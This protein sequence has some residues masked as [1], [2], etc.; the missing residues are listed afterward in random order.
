MTTACCA[1]APRAPSGA[2]PERVGLRRSTEGGSLV[3]FARS[4]PPA[5]RRAR[6]SLSASP[7]AAG[8]FDRSVSPRPTPGRLREAH[9][10]RVGRLAW[11]VV[12]VASSAL[13][14]KGSDA[15][16]RLEAKG[17]VVEGRLDVSLQ[18]LELAVGLD[19]D[20]NGEVTWGELRSREAFTKPYLK[21]GL[22]VRQGDAPCSIELDEVRVVTH[23]DGAYGAWPFRARCPAEVTALSLDYALLFEVDAQHRGLVQVTGVDGGQ[24][25]AFSSASRHLEVDL[26]P[27]APLT[28]LG[29]AFFEGVH[30]LAIGLDHLCFLFALLLPSVLRRDGRG[31]VPTETLKGTLL[32]VTKVVTAFTLAHSVTLGLSAFGVLAPDP[33]LVEVAIA[34]SV[35]LAALNT[36]F[37]VVTEGRWVLAFGLGLLHGFGFVSALTDLGAS[38]GSLAVSLLGFNL[39]VEAGQLA[40]VALVVPLIFVMRRTGWYSRIAVPAGGVVLVA[41]ASWW[42][43]E[44]VAGL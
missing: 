29:V 9:F 32:E 8:D 31:W 1:T 36:V 37:P 25:R 43:V 20:G 44:R 24:W 3:A 38:G 30:H 2:C 11:L 39:G 18:D 4:V 5:R 34:V 22:M 33:G 12:L 15:L 28:Q 13:A 40:V 21:R 19:G 27:P 17:S 7:R 6:L 35:L 23:S 26:R 42:T 41:L 10:F 14:H 16:W